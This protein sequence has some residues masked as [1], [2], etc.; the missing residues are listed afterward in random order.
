MATVNE[1]VSN[2]SYPPQFQRQPQSNTLVIYNSPPPLPLKS[3]VT[4]KQQLM[5]K[6]KHITRIK[7]QIKMQAL[8]IN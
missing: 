7:Q 5:H 6:K 3:L 1:I 8:N 2:I 4:R